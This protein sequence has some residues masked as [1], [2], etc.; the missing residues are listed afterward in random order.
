VTG[1]AG[2]AL[3]SVTVIYLTERSLAE[4]QDADAF[5]IILTLIRVALRKYEAARCWAE[6]DL[7]HP[8]RS[9]TPYS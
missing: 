2:R 3:K 1:I 7:T 4:A 9:R 5:E 8:A 6:W